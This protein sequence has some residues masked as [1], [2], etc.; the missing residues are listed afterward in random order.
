MKEEFLGYVRPDGTTGI[1]NQVLIIPGSFEAQKVCAAV[2]GTVMLNNADLGIGRTPEDRETIA[3]VRAG[4][5]RNPNIY[6]AV[7]LG[8]GEA[9]Q[10]QLS[11]MRLADDIEACG[12]PVIRI[13]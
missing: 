10:K 4:L 3:R 5:G 11:Y 1:R 6:G 13:G 9:D 8:L 2:H 7:V 12:K